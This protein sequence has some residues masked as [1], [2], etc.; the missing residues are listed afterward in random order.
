M[1]LNLS[2]LRQLWQYGGSKLHKLDGHC[3]ELDIVGRECINTASSSCSVPKKRNSQFHG[4]TDA[5]RVMLRKRTE[6]VFILGAL[7]CAAFGLGSCGT[8][9]M[10]VCSLHCFAYYVE[11]RHPAMY[12]IVMPLC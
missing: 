2:V 1:N 11:W 9:P 3:V 5:M 10:Y 8:E 7:G 12:I 6:E 4:L